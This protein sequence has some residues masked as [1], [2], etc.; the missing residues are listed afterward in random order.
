[1]LRIVALSRP[2]EGEAENGDGFFLAVSDKR[3]KIRE[4]VMSTPRAVDPAGTMEQIEVGD[5]ERALLAVV[6]GVGHGAA[7]AE[8]TSKILAALEQHWRLDLA[9]LVQE[10]H[11]AA[12]RSRGATLGLARISLSDTQVSLVGVGDVR[13]QLVAMPEHGKPPEASALEIHQAPNREW[14]V[15]PTTNNNGTVGYT[16]PSKLQKTACGFQP[17]DLLVMSSDGVDPIPARPGP[18]FSE[19]RESEEIARSLLSRFGRF[20]DDAT[21]IVAR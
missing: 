6:D 4:M 20:Q 16:L 14:R 19:R 21:V 7:A 15:H 5:C 3:D 11:R 13:L 1:M 2:L 8:V 12:A 17:G 10:C 18:Q 9:L